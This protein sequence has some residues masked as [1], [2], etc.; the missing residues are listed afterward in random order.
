MES[1][2]RRAAH[3]F[4]VFGWLLGLFPIVQGIIAGDFR[5]IWLAAVTLFLFVMLYIAVFLPVYGVAYPGKL[6]AAVLAAFAAL[7]IAATAGYGGIWFILFLY[8][9]A[10]CGVSLPPR[11]NVSAV[12]AV[13]AVAGLVALYRGETAGGIGGYLFG[14]FAAGMLNVYVARMRGLIRELRETREELA[15]VAVERERLRFARDLHD[16]LGHTLSLIVVKSEAVRRLSERGESAEVTRQASDI[17][18]VGR[19]ALAEVREAVTGY[20]ERSLTSELDNARSALAGAGVDVKIQVSSDPLPPRADTLLGRAVREAVTNVIRHSRANT[21][22]IQVRQCRG[23]ALLE[24]RDDGKG[25]SP[26]SGGGL[27]GL[28]ERTSDAGGRFRAGPA[29]GGGS[30]SQSRSRR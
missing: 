18:A 22:E 24:V 27:T 4:S 13:T 20:R 23:E 25:G 14:C 21:C 8:V 7:T 29:P 17:E 9:S 3:I 12:V 28:A 30:S 26:K 10:A 5:P 15:L 1:I 2:Q 16:L 19:S 6:T 11:W